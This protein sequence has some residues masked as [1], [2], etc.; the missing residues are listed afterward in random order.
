MTRPQVGD[1]KVAIRERH[2]EAA[3]TVISNECEKSFLCFM[4]ESRFL[5][6]F[7]PVVCKPGVEMTVGGSGIQVADFGLKHK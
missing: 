7:I 2:I 3:C 5:L 1:F 6:E 4:P